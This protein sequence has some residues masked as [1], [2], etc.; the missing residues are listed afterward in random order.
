MIR[1]I[2]V[3]PAVF[4]LLAALLS[5]W[6]FAQAPESILARVRQERQPYLDTLRELVSIESGSSDIQGLNAIAELI[7]GRLRALGGEVE[8]VEPPANMVRFEN[9]P[10]QTGK[11]IVARFKGTGTKRILLL[12]HMDTVYLRGMLAKQPFRVDGDRAYGL[13]IDDDKHGV[14]LILHAVTVLKALNLRDYGLLTVLINGD[15]EV[16]SAGSRTL[17][18]KLGSEHDLV[19]SC[20]GAGQQDEIR[21]TTAGIAAVQLKVTGRASHAG[22]APE[23]GRNAL[24]ELAHQIL[25][26]RDLSNAETG[27][28]MNWTLATAGSARNVIPAEARATADVRVLRVADYDG[29]EQQVRDRIKNQLIPDTRVEMVFERTRPPLEATPAARAVAAHAQRIYGEIGLRLGV[30]ASAPGGGTDAAFASLQTKAAVIE[31]FGLR[32][33]GAHSNDAEYIEIASIEPRLYLM[34]RLI[35][36]ASQGKAGNTTN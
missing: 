3:V 5:T 2:R 1:W 15:E 7:A 4:A 20:E 36:D 8:F 16:S 17:I 29:I 34:V 18:T 24:Y 33:F 6:A 26:T 31:G 13:G 10:P 30:Q 35:M 19:L 21:L 9:T 22:G 32:G 12:A 27:V 23:Q 28:K 14:A 11:S 25:Q